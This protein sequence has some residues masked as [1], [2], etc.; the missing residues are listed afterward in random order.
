MLGHGIAG[1]IVGMGITAAAS[2]TAADAQRSF[3]T[4]CFG[5]TTVW[6]PPC[7]SPSQEA[8]HEGA[9]IT[10]PATEPLNGSTFTSPAILNISMA[11]TCRL[12]ATITVQ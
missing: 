1:V 4:E 7:G 2:I 3:A 12:P 9:T 8:L 5:N 10:F 6:T 11:V